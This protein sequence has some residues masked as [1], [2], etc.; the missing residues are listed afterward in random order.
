MG[1]KNPFW[2]FRFGET[3]T[4]NKLRT[5]WGHKCWRD[6]IFLVLTQSGISPHLASLGQYS[7][8][9]LFGQLSDE[10]SESQGGPEESRLC[11]PCPRILC[12]AFYSKC[13]ILL[14]A[15]GLHI[16]PF[17]P[18]AT[19]PAACNCGSP[20]C[21]AARTSGGRAHC[22]CPPR[23]IPAPS[24]QGRASAPAGPPDP[25][26]SAATWWTSGNTRV[27]RQSGSPGHSHLHTQSLHGPGW[28]PRPGRGAAGRSASWA[29][30]QA[31]LSHWKQRHGSSVIVLLQKAGL[32][33]L[34]T[35]FTIPI[36]PLAQLPREILR[37]SHSPVLPLLQSEHV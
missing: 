32:S 10:A 13:G 20:W 7:L 19:S 15:P 29:R 25:Q 17:S 30:S 14:N 12:S 11:L 22:R 9:D 36:K 34:P 35:S 18:Q 16:F 24:H 23:G 37:R 21:G 33:C 1:V 2:Y 28:W 3:K 6:E 26:R 8:S 5:C 4:M 31:R 27:P